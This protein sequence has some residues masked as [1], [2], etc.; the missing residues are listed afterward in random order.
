MALPDCPAWQRKGQSVLAALAAALVLAAGILAV[1]SASGQGYPWKPGRMQA[2]PME[3]FRMSRPAWWKDWGDGMGIALGY[4]GA[5]RS[6]AGDLEELPKDLED[7]H[8]GPTEKAWIGTRSFRVLPYRATLD[9]EP[10]GGCLYLL[11]RHGLVHRWDLK[12]VGGWEEGGG[13]ALA[14]R[15]LSTLEFPGEAEA[16]IAYSGASPCPA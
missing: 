12:A 10:V 1:R 8:R 6:R 4:R 15:I 9:G 2:V 13:D 5:F 7:V 3:G 11:E 16:P 14:R